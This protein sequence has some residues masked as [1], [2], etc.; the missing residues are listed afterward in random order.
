MFSTGGKVNGTYFVM[1]E[2][3]KYNAKLMGKRQVAKLHHLNQYQLFKI[4]P[5]GSFYRK[6]MKTWSG[7]EV[8]KLFTSSEGRRGGRTGSL[9]ALQLYLQFWPRSGGGVAVL[10]YFPHQPIMF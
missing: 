3:R 9:K 7:K 1:S 2:C 6:N 8:P 4:T 5:N 10:R